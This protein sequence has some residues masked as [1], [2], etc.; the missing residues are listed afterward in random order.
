MGRCLQPWL[1]L[2]WGYL[3]Y[4]HEHHVCQEEAVAEELRTS[5]YA[6]VAPTERPLR[7]QRAVGLVE[8]SLAAR[9]WHP[10]NLPHAVLELRPKELEL[11]QVEEGPALTLPASD[12]ASGL[13]LPPGLSPPSHWTKRPPL[14]SLAGL[15]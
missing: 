11:E 2:S 9:R 4:L 12:S 8:E 3:G 15:V 13:T 7:Q 10:K 5:S 1:S 14:L 6:E